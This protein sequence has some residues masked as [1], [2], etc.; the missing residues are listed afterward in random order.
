MLNFMKLS[1]N[2]V[3]SHEST[4]NCEQLTVNSQQTSVLHILDHAV[5]R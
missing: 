5:V 3:I 2:L 4:V 1:H